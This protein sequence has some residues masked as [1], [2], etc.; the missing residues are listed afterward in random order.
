MR[1]RQARV[2]IRGC[3][4]GNFR[5]GSSYSKP[6]CRNYYTSSRNMADTKEYNHEGLI[7][8]KHEAYHKLEATEKLQEGDKPL[9]LAITC[10]HASNL[11]PEGYEWSQKDERVR[12]MHWGSD[13]GARDLTMEL[14][15]RI[16]GG[17]A[18]IGSV[19]R[20]LID[21]N[22]K[23]SDDTLCRTH[24]DGQEVELNN[25]TNL[26]PEE[27]EKRIKQFYTP[28]HSQI[29]TMVTEIT[30]KA[31]TWM[32]KNKVESL[33]G[34]IF[35][36]HSFTPQYEDK[37]K[38]EVEIGVLFNTAEQ[39]LAVRMHKKL[40]ALTNYEVRLNEPYSSMEEGIAGHR[41]MVKVNKE[42]RKQMGAHSNVDWLVLEIETRQDLVVNKEWRTKLVDALVEFWREERLIS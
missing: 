10:E 6:S 8:E 30:E 16:R 41:A 34:C 17:R 1:G 29:H 13:I 23:L 7:V 24:A 36:I 11:L 35:S 3:R 21:M 22:R 2:L 28:Y 39:D 18:V 4:G 5:Q 37:P 14:V 12:N 27:K 33:P 20:L 31:Q 15:S 26:S 19:S 32:E 9:R 40:R 38:R 42:Q 25:V